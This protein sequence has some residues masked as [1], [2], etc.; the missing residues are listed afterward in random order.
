MSDLQLTI[1][2]ENDD[3]L[4][5]DTEFLRRAFPHVNQLLP[6]LSLLIADIDRAEL[7]IQKITGKS[8]SAVIFGAV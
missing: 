1:T 3:F 2:F 4:E 5:T 8:M 6:R 7:N